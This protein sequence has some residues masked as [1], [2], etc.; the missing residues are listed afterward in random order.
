MAGDSKEIADAVLIRAARSGDARAFGRLWDRHHGA[1]LRYAQRLVGPSDAED[2]VSESF[3]SIYQ[4]MRNGAGPDELFRPYL[5]TSLKNLSIRWSIRESAFTLDEVDFDTFT[6]STT[7]EDAGL[8]SLERS[9]EALAFR[10]L[11]E[12]WQEVLWYGEVEGLKPRDMAPILGMSAN[13][14]A[15]LAY[16]ARDGF[17]KA[18][19]DL[20]AQD[21][22]AA[23]R[24]RDEALVGRLRAVLVPLLL[25]IPLADFLRDA[26]PGAPVSVAAA[27]SPPALSAPTITGV[28]AGAAAVGAASILVVSALAWTGADQ[29]VSGM[30]APAS[31]TAPLPA[32][33]EPDDG[34]R[35]PTPSEPI[36]DPATSAP[37]P[38]DVPPGPAVPPASVPVIALPPATSPLVYSP[39]VGQVVPGGVVQVS[40]A[41]TAGSEVILAVDGQSAGTAV[42]APDGSWEHGLSLPLTDG[43]HDLAVV[44]R[45]AVRS[46]STAVSV[47]FIVDSIAPVEPT[48]STV[49]D[50]FT[51]SPP[52][53][54]GS[55][56]PGS[57]VVIATASGEIATVVA[58]GAGL[59]STAPLAGVEAHTTQLQVTQTDR[60]GNSSVPLILPIAFAPAFAPGQPAV[61]SVNSFYTFTGIAWPGARVR[62]YI[63]GQAVYFSGSPIQVVPASGVLTVYYGGPYVSVGS[64]QLTIAYS[65]PLTDQPLS[66]ETLDFTV[67]P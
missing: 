10:S 13:A 53:L 28:L 57:T 35:V 30:D 16:R 41:G 46:A 2:L 48:V 4:T 36:R 22:I 25:G 27:A 32:Y 3:T 52:A 31:A 7:A 49:L 39:V 64:H 8:A 63:D 19:L 21:G 59:W 12:R 20:R 26:G 54:S 62:T 1:A 44:Q 37:G 40:G 24:P 29:A 43:A 5:Y 14:V 9:Y 11:P 50:R 17:R 15:A 42:V 47:P 34:D 55:A 45:S 18:W 38:S 61:Y 60:A 66:L 65:D 56:E 6:D 58:D 23:E 51:T 67:Q 33:G